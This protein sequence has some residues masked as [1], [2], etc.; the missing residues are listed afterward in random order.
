MSRFNNPKHGTK[1]VNKAGGEAYKQSPEM[2]LISL[3]VTNF[4]NEQYYRSSDESFQELE[5]LINICPKDFVA[6]AG[7]YARTKFGMRSITHVLAAHVADSIAGEPWAKSF[8][9]KIIYRVDDMIEIMAL[10]DG[11]ITHAMEKGFAKAFDKFDGYQ[12][13]KYRNE[14]KAWK[15]VDVV[16]LVHPKPN[17]KNAEALARLVEDKLRSQDTW[18][19]E[20]KKDGKAEAWGKL[21]AERKIGYFALLRNLRNIMQDAP[22]SLDDALRMLTEQKLI[23]KSLVLPFRYLTAMKEIE[24]LPDSRKVMDALEEALE[25][26][27]DN[28]PELEGV[29]LI[30]L[31][32]S[33]SMTFNSS[34]GTTPAEI[35]GIFGSVLYKKN[36]TS[37]FLIFDTSMAWVNFN[38]KDS[39]L[40]MAKTIPYTGGGTDFRL[41]FTN[42][43]RKYDRIVILSDM[44]AWVGYNTPKHE[45]DTYRNIYGADP[46]VYCFDLQGYGTLQFPERN[47]YQL[48]GFSEKV[49]DVMKLLETDPKAIITEVNK[50][51]L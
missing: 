13:A 32:V 12:L 23:H 19:S 38:S 33:G 28:V 24:K 20:I 26:S 9:E 22:E 27:L 18:E 10:R 47:V 3:L 43:K 35:G 5:G 7:V 41:I 34:R 36:L 42:L 4:A 11:K 25:L 49:F 6:K 44:Q 51:E 14:G 15:L 2:A 46:M 8:F 17:E 40:T 30:A 39:I 37:D 21:I 48:A 31:D 45:F 50:I 29:T 1:T 16:N